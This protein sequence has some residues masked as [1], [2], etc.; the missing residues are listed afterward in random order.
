MIIVNM[1]IRQFYNFSSVIKQY[2][3]FARQQWILRKE[4]YPNISRYSDLIRGD[5]GEMESLKL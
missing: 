5:Q 3:L 1:F 2:S 4:R